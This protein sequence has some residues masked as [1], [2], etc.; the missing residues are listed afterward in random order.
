MKT[1]EHRVAWLAGLIDGDGCISTYIEN[2]RYVRQ[3]DGDTTQSVRVALTVYNTN[4]TILLEAML[5]ADAIGVEYDFKQLPRRE[6]KHKP[7]FCV[8]FMGHKRVRKMLEALLP[9]LVGKATQAAIVLKVMNHCAG[10]RKSKGQYR[11]NPKDDQWLT[12]Q[13]SELS[14]LNQRGVTV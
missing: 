3:A 13:L 7:Y 9:F 4:E 1:F 8:R 12:Q 14:A 11:M 10:L 6:A 5:V 2:S